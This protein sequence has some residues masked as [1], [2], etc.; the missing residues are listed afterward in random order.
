MARRKVPAL[1]FTWKM[2]AAF[3][4][5][6]RR[7]MS[8]LSAVRAEDAYVPLRKSPALFESFL[9]EEWLAPGLRDIVAAAKRGERHPDLKEEASDIFSFDVFTESFCATFLEE[10]D[11]Y[12]ASGLP[13]RRPNSMNNY[14]LIVNEIG[15]RPA[16][17]ALQQEILQPIAN[18]L[19]P[20]VGYEFRDHHSF[21]VQY[22]PNE[23]K[24]LDMHT[25]D[26]DV[27]F[28]VCLG[29]TF[30]GAGLT[31][32][33]TVAE[34]AHRQ[35]SFQY[36]H[37]KGRAVVHRG[38]RR[39]GADDI[40][41]GTRR[42]LI[43]WNHNLDYRASPAYSRRMHNYQKESGPPDPRCLSFTHD[44]DYDAYKTKTKAQRSVKS[45]PWC[46]PPF[47]CYDQMADALDK[48]TNSDP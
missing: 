24:G 22:K 17:T 5:T 38:T 10:V 16:L 41:E 13:V 46:P 11:S 18:V 4:T 35:F 34:A 32:C 29:D 12:G 7:F 39:H 26:S 21:V 36:V 31:F 33:G 15:L 1:L 42:N 48:A 27:T 44:R 3:S 2:G 37:C 40:T 19:F 47:A 8:S 23:D 20:D 14:G 25:D 30:E 45:R 6:P 28:N 43:V 9:R